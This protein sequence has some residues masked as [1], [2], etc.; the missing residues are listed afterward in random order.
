MTAN[1]FINNELPALRGF[2]W[3]FGYQIR[4]NNF[5]PNNTAHLPIG[6]FCPLTAAY[7]LK[8]RLYLPTARFR[9]AGLALGLSVPDIWVIQQAVDSAPSHLAIRKR[10]IEVLSK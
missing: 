6:T 4:C 9:D 8:N 2:N 5:Y 1:E 3:A 10:I 7:W